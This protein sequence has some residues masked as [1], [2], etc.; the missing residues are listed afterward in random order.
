MWGTSLFWGGKWQCLDLVCK[1]GQVL[2]YGRLARIPPDFSMESGKKDEKIGA[3][4]ICLPTRRKAS[5]G[6]GCAIQ[7]GNK[8][9]AISLPL[10]RT[11]DQKTN[12]SGVFRSEYATGDT[13][14]AP[15]LT[16]EAEV[17]PPMHKVRLRFFVT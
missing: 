3:A 6:A 10:V 17:K 2:F 13:G 16:P 8:R 7:A 1:P 12:G 11:I 14:S 4:L 9:L 15:H 5:N